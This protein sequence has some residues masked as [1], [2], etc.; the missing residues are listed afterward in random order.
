MIDQPWSSLLR[1][2]EGLYQL[3]GQTN[4]VMVLRALYLLFRNFIHTTA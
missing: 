3:N 1:E 2:N 4:L